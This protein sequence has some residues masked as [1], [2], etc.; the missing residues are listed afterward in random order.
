MHLKFILAQQG[1][2]NI[3]NRIDIAEVAYG[4]H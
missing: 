1:I 4:Y 2:Y 3:C